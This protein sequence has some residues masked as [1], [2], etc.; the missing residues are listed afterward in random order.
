DKGRS[1]AV[2]CILEASRAVSGQDTNLCDRGELENQADLLRHIVGNP[3]R[4]YPAPEFW[5]STVTMLAQA[6]YEGQDCWFALHDA[7]VESGH[8]E[9]A[10]HFTEGE[11]HPK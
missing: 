2:N 9:L 5:P 3:F 1:S 8:P 6:M 4:P 11:S 7:L 10:D